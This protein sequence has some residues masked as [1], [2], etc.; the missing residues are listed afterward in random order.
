LETLTQ[1]ALNKHCLEGVALQNAAQEFQDF[2][3]SIT[4][5]ELSRVHNRKNVAETM[6]DPS[7]CS[8]DFAN[9]AGWVCALVEGRPA[10][11]ENN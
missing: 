6:K 8:D 3:P 2:P 1:I 7:F 10:G 4:T 9:E 5:D 11:S